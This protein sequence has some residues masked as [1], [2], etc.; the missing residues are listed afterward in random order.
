[1]KA[2][3]LLIAIIGMTMSA[4]ISAY[5]DENKINF[6]YD[7]YDSSPVGLTVKGVID[8]LNETKNKIQTFVR[9]ANQYIPILE[10]LAGASNEL[11]YEYFYRINVAGFVF[12]VY[13]N[14]NLYVGWRV[15]PGG[16]T[17]DRFDVV[18]TPFVYG[19]AYNRVNGTS[20]PAVGAHEIGIVYAHAYAPI[21]LQLF[22]SRKVCFQGSYVVEP[23]MV[24]NNLFAALNACENEILDKVIAGAGFLDFKC[25][26]TNPVNVTL[27]EKNFTT[28]TAGDFI[29]QSCFSF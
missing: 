22:S 27:I 12:D 23:V 16:Q 15:T 5:A 3:I 6:A 28:R 29:A 10:A 1:M 21:A 14:F 11:K 8:P 7:V 24:K 18:Y 9:L 20:F 2:V 17:S 25:N 4:P 19:Y 13:V 26:Y